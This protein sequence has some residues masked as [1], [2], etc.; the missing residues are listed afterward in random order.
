MIVEFLG[1]LFVTLI[2]VKFY[3]GKFSWECQKNWEK[4]TY[5]NIDSGDLK[6]S[7]WH[8]DFRWSLESNDTFDPKKWT[9]L[10]CPN[11]LNTKC[12]LL[13]KVSIYES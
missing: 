3:L 5:E 11:D 12:V 6:G 13:L 1:G 9:Y 2:G 7:E 10:K 8:D 4:S